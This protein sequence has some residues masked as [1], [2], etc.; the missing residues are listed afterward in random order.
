MPDISELKRKIL[1][2]DLRCRELAGEL[3]MTA[4][5]RVAY[6]SLRPDLQVSTDKRK[7]F[8]RRKLRRSLETGDP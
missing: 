3:T 4:T 1:L 8:N 7:T 5:E 6:S 2:M